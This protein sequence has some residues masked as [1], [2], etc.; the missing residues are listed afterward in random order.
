MMSC[1]DMYDKEL[2]V[3]QYR[4]FILVDV[5]YALTSP[6]NSQNP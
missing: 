4:N 6:N 2:K 5:I 1:L 3:S